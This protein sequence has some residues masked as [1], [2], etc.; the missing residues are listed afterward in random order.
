MVY[1]LSEILEMFNELKKIEDSQASARFAYAAMRNYKLCEAQSEIIKEY[2]TKAIEGGEQYRKERMI[3][4]DELVEKDETGKP[5]TIFNPTDGLTHYVFENDQKQSMF[6]KKVEKLN[7]RHKEYLDKLSERQKKLDEM[8]KEEVDMEFLQV[9]F[10]D[11]PTTITPK[12]VRILS[13]M[14]KEEKNDK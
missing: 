9:S 11:F 7:D 1:K 10:R 6:L 12:Q 2:A 8:L 5:K 14:I 3:L 4:V 13:F